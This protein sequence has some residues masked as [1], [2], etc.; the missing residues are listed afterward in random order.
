MHTI[1]EARIFGYVGQVRTADDDSRVSFSVATSRKWVDDRGH[2]REETDWHQVIAFKP[3]RGLLERLLKGARVLLDGRLQ[4]REYEKDGVKRKVTEIVAQPAR[5]EVV[6][7]PKPKSDDRAWSAA[8]EG[9]GGGRS[10]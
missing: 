5:V 6:Q 1:N 2:S 3:P 9:G 7:A 4:T 10:G 8:G